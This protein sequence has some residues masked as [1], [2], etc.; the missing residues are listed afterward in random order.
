MNVVA[1]R[2]NSISAELSALKDKVDASPE[3]V[4][5]GDQSRPTHRD[6]ETAVS[7]VVTDMT[8]RLTDLKRSIDSIKA[9]VAKETILLE[10]SL[11]RKIETNVSKML[12][13]KVNAA[14]EA[15]M[16][17]VK[18]LIAEEISKIQATS[19]PAPTPVVEDTADFEITIG[20]P[21]APTAP[22]TKPR[23]G[24][25]RKQA[26]TASVDTSA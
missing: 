8:R 24:G 11:T 17:I 19:E 18:D 14:I 13:D 7:N 22:A 2:V 20:N 9:D 6:V 4:A 15:Q 21:V 25:R 12:S 3:S 16:S 23:V 26:A 1:S 10:A 5:E